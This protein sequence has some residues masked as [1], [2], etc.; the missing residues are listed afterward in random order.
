[1]GVL[2]KIIIKFFLVVLFL[3]IFFYPLLSYFKT[4]QTNYFWINITGDIKLTPKAVERYNNGEKFNIDRPRDVR[5]YHNIDAYKRSYFESRIFAI[6]NITWKNNFNGNYQQ[7]LEIPRTMDLIIYTQQELPRVI[8]VDSSKL[9]YD[10]DL[11]WTGYSEKQLDKPTFSHYYDWTT[12]I[13]PEIR[14]NLIKANFKNETQNKLVEEDLISADR[15][16]GES[17]FKESN[18]TL[19]HLIYANWFLQRADYRIQYFRLK[20]INRTIFKIIWLSI[21]P[22]NSVFVIEC[23]TL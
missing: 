10:V 15:E 18:E 12:R 21:L 19:L 4:Y 2:L 22:S 5:I 8:T 7:T 3:T 9:N 6:S 11:F 23:N 16:I 1:M 14:G 17:G 20:N 13:R